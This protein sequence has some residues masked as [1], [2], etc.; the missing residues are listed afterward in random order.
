MMF[1]ALIDT[2]EE[3]DKF[4]AL[5]EKYKN[6]MFIS[7]NKIINDKHLSEDILQETFIK[8]ANNI[9]CVDDDIE[10]LRTKSFIMTITKNTALDY[11]R[12]NVKRREVEIFVEEIEEPVFYDFDEEVD[13]NVDL[14][15]R[16]II[17]F[18][19][20]KE[21]YRNIFIL[22]YVSKL[23][24]K[25]IARVE[26]ISEELVRQRLSRGKKMLEKKLEG[27]RDK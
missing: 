11:Y 26:G 16:M 7:I 3:Q 22:K 25:E 12:K 14:E 27:M 5:F 1:L 2:E 17:L 6:I 8:I 10:S 4:K 21:N 18:S 23:D 9:D 15:E 19:K 13:S 24:N 20:M